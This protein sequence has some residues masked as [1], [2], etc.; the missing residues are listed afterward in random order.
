VKIQVITSDDSGG[1][2]A[3]EALWYELAAAA[4]GG[5]HEVSSLITQRSA[6]HGRVVELQN[7]GLQLCHRWSAPKEG[8]LLPISYKVWLRMVAPWFWSRRLAGAVDLRVLNVGTMIEAAME[9]WATLLE[10][11]VCP[12]AV[13]VH[14][15][16][17]IRDYPPVLLKRLR[18]VLLGA[19]R[20]Y[21]VSKRLWANAEE[22]L[23]ERIPG[24]QVVRNPV[25][26]SSRFIEP[27][28]SQNGCLRMAAVGRLD[29]FVKGQV[30]LLHAL[31]TDSWR[32]R[33]W[34]LTIF[35]SGP[36]LEKIESAV[37]FYGL[38]GKVE[39]GGFVE[40][41]RA[42]V[43][44]DHHLLVMPSMIEGMPLTLVEAMV[45]GRPALCSDV[46]GAREL[47][48]DGVTGFLAGSPFAEQM[49]EGLERVWNRRQDLRQM[50]QLAHE[51]AVRFLPVDP[52][53]KLLEDIME[54]ILV[55]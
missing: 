15:N 36:D 5:G 20:V 31:S 8:R 47:V 35:G 21:F 54:V 29:A 30:R 6:C 11:S 9:P 7:E 48:Q 3:C 27:W 4:L 23:L 53:A 1:A 43:W 14:S 39:F 41:V 34:K 55:R 2:N 18:R 46:G 37:Q 32:S 24:A 25:N 51:D 19:A 16:S 26:L 22:Q 17:E 52:G 38:R 13:I 10:R 12:Y 42:S 50:G 44:K 33:D 45:C 49:G 40:D 28:P